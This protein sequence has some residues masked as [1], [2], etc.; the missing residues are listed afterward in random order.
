MN[1]KKRLVIHPKILLRVCLIIC[2]IMLFI[3]FRYQEEMMP[4][5]TAVGDIVTPMQR[6]INTLGTYI[7]DKMDMLKNVNSLILENQQLKSE[8]ES[9]K[10][11]N[12]YR[13]SDMYELNNLRTLYQVG[14]KYADYPK[15]AAKVI[16]KESNSYYS[17]FTI[18]KGENDGIALDMNVLAGDGL[19]GIVIEVGRN[20]SKVRSI[21]DD[22]SYVSG[23]FLK[24]SDTCD[25]KGD[26][27][28]LDSGYIRVETIS[29]NAEIED[30]YEVVTSHISDKY[31]QGILIGYITNIEVDSSDMSKRAYLKPVV[32]FEHLEDVLVITKLKKPL[33]SL[34]DEN[35]YERI[36]ERASRLTDKEKSKLITELQI[37]IDSNVK[38]DDDIENDDDTEV[39]NNIN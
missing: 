38:A 21:I 11:Q 6:G 24:T 13:T 1:R 29:K 23:M 9:L 39:D 18:D 30:N 25:V 5:K 22:S 4:L 36:F 33:E 16:S 37:E 10:V 20:H 15:V 3:S 32:D 8:A 12:R 26:L 27:K 2:T 34:P 35:S 28:L 19:C 14:E 17:V 7:S 31:L